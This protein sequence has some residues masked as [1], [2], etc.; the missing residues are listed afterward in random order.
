MHGQQNVKK[1]SYTRRTEGPRS[2]WPYIQLHTDAQW[3]FEK[4]ENFTGHWVYKS[5]FR[6]PSNK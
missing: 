2:K 5:Y 3:I 1:K 6:Y 4:N